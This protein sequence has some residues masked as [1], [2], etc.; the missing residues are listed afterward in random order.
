MG[1]GMDGWMK[2]CQGGGG[3]HVCVYVYK[4][5]NIPQRCQVGDGI[6][7]RP[8]C[9]FTTLQQHVG[10]LQQVHSVAV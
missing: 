5:I 6:R 9:Q 2:G 7:G 1:G 10:R 3:V 8:Q 4:H